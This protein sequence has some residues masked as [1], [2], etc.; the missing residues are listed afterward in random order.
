MPERDEY[1]IK[2]TTE[3]LCLDCK[4]TS[5]ASQPVLSARE[6]D[7]YHV[8]RVVAGNPNTPKQVLAHLSEDVLPT[9][10]RRVAENPRTTP[11]ILTNLAKDMDCDVR[12]SVAEN[13]S[14]PPEILSML[15]C[16]EDVD[17]RF[18]VAENPHMPEDI[19]LKLS[20]DDNPYIRCRA[21]KT[22]QMLAPD[23]Q[24]RLKLMIGSHHGETA[25]YHQGF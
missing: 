10:R 5:Q 7:V 4:S 24:S 15:S 6:F 25:R 2:G 19:L 8:R 3:E 23:V 13:P 16:D 1:Y 22:L 18:G 17:V 11:E 9:I 21:L 14:T 12:L 20:E